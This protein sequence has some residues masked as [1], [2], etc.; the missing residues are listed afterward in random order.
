MLIVVFEASAR[1][2]GFCSLSRAS[3][4]L[5]SIRVLVLHLYVIE[6][7]MAKLWRFGFHLY[8]GCVSFVDFDVVVIATY[9]QHLALLE[10]GVM[11]RCT[12][13]NSIAFMCL[14]HVHMCIFVKKES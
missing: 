2:W 1:C 7:D 4:V 13:G 5:V 11:L 14:P 3:S 10:F 12:L 8:S 6:M 9:R